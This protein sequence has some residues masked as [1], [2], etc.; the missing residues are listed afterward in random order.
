M[1]I[2]INDRG[3]S[4]A[5]PCAISPAAARLTTVAFASARCDWSRSSAGERR[6]GFAMAPAKGNSRSP[7]TAILLRPRIRSSKQ[8]TQLPERLIRTA[9]RNSSFGR[10]SG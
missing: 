1:A 2:L 5:Q 7:E 3:R 10:D 4:T 6:A 9:V 8:A